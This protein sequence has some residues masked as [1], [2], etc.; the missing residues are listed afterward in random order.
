LAKLAASLHKPDGMDLINHQNL[1]STL[2]TLDL[3]DL[4]GIASRNKAR[5]NSYGIMTPLQFL[6]ASPELLKR[7]VFKSVCGEDWSKRLRGYE[8]DDYESTTKVDGRQFV[9]DVSRPTD[10][11]LMSRL[12][13]LSET[14]GMKLRY[15]GL[16]A[17]GIMVYARYQSGDYW[18]SRKMFKS[19]FF[20]NSE[21]TRRAMLL[22][23][24]RPRDSYVKEIGVSCYMLSKSSISQISLF[25][26]VNHEAWLTE[27]VDEINQTFGEFTIAYANSHMSKRIVKQKIPFGSTKYFELL[28]NQK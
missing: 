24:N 18:Y 13:Y 2:S 16:C 3:T 17:R 27:A 12:S 1:R 28:F 21:I 11:I 25:D 19:T 7:N 4:S 14:T 10:E 5:L 6:D 15:N 20:S 9:M 8:V 26:D 22:F 23:D